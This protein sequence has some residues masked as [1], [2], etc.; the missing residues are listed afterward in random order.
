MFYDV[1]MEKRA[2]RYDHLARTSFAGPTARYI[3]GG[4]L[5]GGAAGR[6]SADD[7]H[8]TRDMLLG[9]TAGG[10]LGAG[11]SRFHKALNAHR[12]KSQGLRG[13][14]TFDA[15]GNLIRER[16]SP[17][18]PTKGAVEYA[19]IEGAKDVA[20]GRVGMPTNRKLRYAV[21]NDVDITEE[22]MPVTDYDGL[23]QDFLSL[24]RERELLRGGRNVALGAGAGFGLSKLRKR[25]KKERS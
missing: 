19:G 2:G 1:L 7:E 6:M 21:R 4:A 25:D 15:S 17:I 8:K 14:H 22:N 23:A 16:L 10:A 9:A 12:M 20:A 13:E 3:L 5:A 18:D 24:G 11:A